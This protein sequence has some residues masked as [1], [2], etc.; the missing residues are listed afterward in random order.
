MAETKDTDKIREHELALK[1]IQADHE[2]SLKKEEIRGST[3]KVLL[4]TAIVGV[5]ASLFPFLQGYAEAHFSKKIEETKAQSARDLA[6]IQAGSA[7]ELAD[8]Q[9]KLDKAQFDLQQSK[10]DRS[11]LSTLA[12][13]GA[14]MDANR[15]IA[16][17]EFYSFL[18]TTDDS[19]ADWTDFRKYLFGRRQDELE[20]LAKIETNTSSNDENTDP[21]ETETVISS[22][23][24]PS[25]T[26]DFTQ[27]SAEEF[28]FG[29]S[30]RTR[31]FNGEYSRV[32][33]Q[34]QL[35]SALRGICPEPDERGFLDRRTVLCLTEALNLSPRQLLE[36][37]EYFEG[38]DRLEVALR[39]GRTL[40]PLRPTDVENWS[41]DRKFFNIIQN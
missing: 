1:R 16:M 12:E 36:Y 38:Q 22:V 25:T 33:S 2:L 30:E 28:L 3:L 17:A 10:E 26:A 29:I 18:A 41:P 23:I 31:A 37:F 24:S 13:T 20:T 4:G 39:D 35:I 14:G 21:D 40:M 27:K 5:A 8:I 7:R 34:I 32:T 9:S 19:K 11:Y 6:A 15:R